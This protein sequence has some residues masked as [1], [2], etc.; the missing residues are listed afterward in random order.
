MQLRLSNNEM[1]TESL[2][3]PMQQQLQVRSR[4]ASS[5]NQQKDHCK[6]EG[7]NLNQEETCLYTSKGQK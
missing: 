7:R 4:G 3:V 1:K 6:P 2:T 5:D